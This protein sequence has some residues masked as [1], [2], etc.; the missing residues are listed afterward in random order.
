MAAKS[1]VVNA[2]NFDAE[3]LQAKGLILVDFWAE[4]CHPCK[5]LAPIMERI[6]EEYASRVKVCK[7]GIDENQEIA[8]RFGVMSIPTV[9][10]FKNGREV[11]RT[12][13]YRP[14]EEFLIIMDK[15]I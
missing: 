6:A 9:I 12:I 2:G 15:N 7:L 4:W 14:F 10:F 11:D 1:V 13:G 8:A 3:I 5:M